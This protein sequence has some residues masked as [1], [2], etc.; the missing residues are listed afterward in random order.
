MTYPVGLTEAGELTE[1]DG[2]FRR[3]KSQGGREV[4]QA[5]KG[6]RGSKCHTPQAD[7]AHV[8]SW[9]KDEEVSGDL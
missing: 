2:V 7:A 6:G 9:I 4:R 3:G 5:K 1:R 8:E